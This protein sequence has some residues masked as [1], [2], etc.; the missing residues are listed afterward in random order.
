MR[1]SRII[2][3]MIVLLFTASLIFSQDNRRAQPFKYEVPLQDIEV[4][5][6]GDFVIHEMYSESGNGVIIYDENG[7]QVK[8]ILN[9]D[10]RGTNIYYNFDN[11][12]YFIKGSPGEGQNMRFN[13]ENGILSMSGVFNK[14]IIP[15]YGPILMETGLTVWD[16]DTGEMLFNTGRNQYLN[17]GDFEALCDYLRP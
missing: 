1:T 12:E 9:T 11:P 16:L 8:T 7:E 3:V 10:F 13:Y 5:S 17:D 14:I 4:T 6:C 15:G 2:A